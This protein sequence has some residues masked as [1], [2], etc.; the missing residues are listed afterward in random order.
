MMITTTTYTETSF[1]ALVEEALAEMEARGETLPD[2]RYGEE[3]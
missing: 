3:D 1:E 2:T